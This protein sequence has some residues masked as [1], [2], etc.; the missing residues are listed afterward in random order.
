MINAPDGNTISATEHSVA[1]I[2]AMAR[3]IPQA[4]ASLKSGEWDRKSFRGTELYRK[5]LG[6]IGTGRIG[7][8]R[9][10]TFAKFWYGYPRL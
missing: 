8:W 1:M 6:V 10:K 5:T 7:N 4:H 9:G 3:N 2:L